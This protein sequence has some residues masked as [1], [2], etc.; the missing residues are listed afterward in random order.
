MR[1]KY[2]EPS[3]LG[4]HKLARLPFGI[5]KPHELI[6]LPFG[7]SKAHELMGLPVTARNINFQATSAFLVGIKKAHTSFA[8]LAGLVWA[9]IKEHL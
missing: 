2:V 4:Y 5:G 1:T 8:R 3:P 7:I 6:G 9:A